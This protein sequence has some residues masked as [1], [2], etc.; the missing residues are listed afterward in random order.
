MISFSHTIMESNLHASSIVAPPV[1]SV[2]AVFF[3][4]MTHSKKKRV[5]LVAKDL[6]TNH[7]ITTF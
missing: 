4:G 3:D 6:N 2:D 1:M 7:N 5:L